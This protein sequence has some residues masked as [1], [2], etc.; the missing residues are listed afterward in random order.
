MSRFVLMTLI[1]Q[2]L[3]ADTAYA[4]SYEVNNE[5]AA[6]L[7]VMKIDMKPPI[8]GD[9]NVIIKVSDAK[10]LCACHASVAFEYSKP[11][12]PG[13]PAFHYALKTE[14]KRGR[15]IGKLSLSM[16]RSWNTAVKIGT[17][18]SEWTTNFTVDVE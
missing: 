16:G 9:N 15:H 10:I 3:P 1:L 4:A 8:A 7:V 2:L 12:M 13:M 18:D 17:G 14:L 6:T 11:A 5:V